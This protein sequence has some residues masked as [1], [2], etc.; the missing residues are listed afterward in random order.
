M[1]ITTERTTTIFNEKKI[2]F[3][4][5]FVRLD[6][7]HTRTFTPQKLSIDFIIFFSFFSS[8]IDRNR[9]KKIPTKWM[10]KKKQIKFY[11]GIRLD[12]KIY[13]ERNKKIKTIISFFLFSLQNYCK[14]SFFL[15]FSLY[16]CSFFSY[17]FVTKRKS[18][19]HQQ[20]IIIDLATVKKIDSLC[21]KWVVPQHFQ[22][23]KKQ[24]QKKNLF[25]FPFKNEIFSSSL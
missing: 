10:K 17:F 6:L 19:I 3:F 16:F 1:E 18:Q 14:F 9:R 25:I 2:F 24:K 21:S 20:K 7:L 13:F 12:K 23:C 5:Q 4:L 11:V 8:S 22:H 15:F